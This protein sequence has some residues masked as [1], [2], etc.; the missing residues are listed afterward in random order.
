MTIP[1]WMN[2]NNMDVQESE[3]MTNTTTTI[4]TGGQIIGREA[5]PAVAL[6][7]ALALLQDGKMHRVHISNE[8]IDY[9][10]KL[11]VEKSIVSIG[12]GMSVAVL[13]QDK[14]KN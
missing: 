14:K 8:S 10:I 2:G 5:S 1:A 9:D 13:L 11:I 3:M 7:P 12:N 4:V 6:L